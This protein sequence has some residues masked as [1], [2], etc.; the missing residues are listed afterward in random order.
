[1]SQNTQENR[2]ESQTTQEVSQIERNGVVY[3]RATT[4]NDGKRHQKNVVMTYNT[5]QVLDLI[6]PVSSSAA[7]ETICSNLRDLMDVSK[8]PSQC[9]EDILGLPDRF[10]IK[11]LMNPFVAKGLSKFTYDWINS[12]EPLERLA[13]LAVIFSF[14]D[15]APKGLKAPKTRITYRYL[16]LPIPCCILPCTPY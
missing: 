8:V 6:D 12:L 10:N 3:T 16:T 9:L 1:M 14:K 7:I 4:P 11:I 15:K 13:L 5:R 2:N